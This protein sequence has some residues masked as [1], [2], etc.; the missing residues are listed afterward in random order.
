MDTRKYLAGLTSS[1]DSISISAFN[2]SHT[3]EFQ[4]QN[5]TGKNK[6]AITL[7]IK[8]QY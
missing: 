1:W 3:P 6:K 2:L 5:V 8:M 7:H 4:Q